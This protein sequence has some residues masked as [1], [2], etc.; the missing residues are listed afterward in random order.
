M[1]AKA[2]SKA[3]NPLQTLKVT[4]KSIYFLF[5][6][7]PFVSLWHVS[8]TVRLEN[9]FDC[10]VDK[11]DFLHIALT[12]DANDVASGTRRYCEGDVF[13]FR[14]KIERSFDAPNRNALD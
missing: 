7:N 14:Q 10:V 3:R 9:K 8:S 6:S 4:K 5:S 13:L 11:S 12:V 2:R 1:E